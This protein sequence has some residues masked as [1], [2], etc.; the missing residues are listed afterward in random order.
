LSEDTVVKVNGKTIKAGEIEGVRWEAYSL[1][2]IQILLKLKTTLIISVVSFIL[3]VYLIHNTFIP[4]CA[5]DGIGTITVDLTNEQLEKY[6]P[7]YHNVCAFFSLGVYSI[8]VF[9]T[10][11]SIQQF[12]SLYVHYVK[13]GSASYPRY[14]VSLLFHGTVLLGLIGC[15][16]PSLFMLTRGFYC[17]YSIIAISV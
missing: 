3:F 7:Y 16:L 1:S 9:F 14:Q 5:L 8:Y 17:Y 10:L 2:G 13:A 15:F 4:G 6:E 11:K 12:G